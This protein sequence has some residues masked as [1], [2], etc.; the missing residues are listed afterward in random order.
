MPPDFIFDKINGRRYLNLLGMTVYSGL[1]KFPSQSKF[2]GRISEDAHNHCI[3]ST[4]RI[5]DVPG[6][7]CYTGERLNN[8]KHWIGNIIGEQIS[9]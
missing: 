1:P 4:E 5:I 3:S 2:I 7:N 6:F 8:Q 9:S